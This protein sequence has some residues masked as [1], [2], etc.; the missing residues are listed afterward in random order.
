M[1]QL[2][3][4]ICLLSSAFTWGE[5]SGIANGVIDTQ[6]QFLSDSAS[7]QETTYEG[8]LNLQTYRRHPIGWL[9]RGPKIKIQQSPSYLSVDTHVSLY[10]F[11]IHQG[12]WFQ[13]QWQ[14]ESMNSEISTSLVY[15][16]D[17]G[18]AQTLN[19][20]DIID[21]ERHLHRAHVYWYESVKDEG[22]INTLGL[23]YSSES[24]PVNAD[25]TSTNATLFDG[26]FSGFGFSLGRIK[27]DRGLNFQ[28]QMYLAKLDSD[29]SN[30]ATQHRQLSSAESTVYQMGFRFDWH[31]RYYLGPYWYLVPS[32]HVDYERL[33]QTQFDPEFVE[34]K[35]FS[36]V[37][38][39]G[40]IALRRYF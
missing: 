23:F 13:F 8:E 39:S 17:S 16:S 10:Q 19:T 9:A 36:W 1:H 38:L 24:S 18:A 22:P 33:L 32:V 26:T 3:F 29:L 12:L 35:Q 20:G 37:Q 28:W 15:V 6:N 7:L 2:L 14:D 11:H 31:Y 5:Y 27:D 4:I 21:F 34:H 30:D 40:F 25:I